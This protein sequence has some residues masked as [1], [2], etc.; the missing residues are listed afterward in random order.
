MAKKTKAAEPL[1][2]IDRQARKL[3]KP[4]RETRAV[5]AIHAFGSIGDQAQM[6]LVCLGMFGLGALR[7]D[8]RMM[9]AGV[10]MLLSHELATLAKDAVKRRVDRTRPRR[11]GR[12]K[13]RKGR[14]TSKEI[15]SF[16]SG[17]SAGSMAVA[18]A[19]AA[20]YPEHRAAAL[21][22]AGAVGLAQ[23]PTCAHYPSDVA[24]G[25]TIGALAEAVVGLAWRRR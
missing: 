4:Y 17:H 1:F 2:E 23:V 21:A 10:R 9:R 6:R 19:F 11:D 13:P 25:M 15:T 3:F 20:E 22:A 8:P 18:R 14:H 7:R 16:P 5:K 24:A 12:T